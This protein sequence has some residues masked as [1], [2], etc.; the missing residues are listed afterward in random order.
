M[1][2]KEYYIRAYKLNVLNEKGLKNL[3]DLLLNPD[4]EALQE[5]LNDLLLENHSC[6]KLHCLDRK[7]MKGHPVNCKICNNCERRVH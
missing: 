2:V 4:R 5:Q 7:R 3:I 1:N 6:L